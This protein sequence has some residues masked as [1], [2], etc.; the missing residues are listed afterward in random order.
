LTVALARVTWFGPLKSGL[1]IDAL[2]A[3]AMEKVEEDDKQS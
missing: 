2:V 3:F 1:A